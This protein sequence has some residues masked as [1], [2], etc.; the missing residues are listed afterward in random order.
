MKIKKYGI[1]SK[2]LIKSVEFILKRKF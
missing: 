2:D 1:K